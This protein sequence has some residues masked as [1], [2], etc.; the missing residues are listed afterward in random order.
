MSP[1]MPPFPQCVPLEPITLGN[2]KYT[3]SGEVRRV[4]GVT[5][6]SASD[7][8][9]F[10]VAHPKPMPPVATEELKHFKQSVQDTSR[11]AKYV[12]HQISTSC[13]MLWLFGILLV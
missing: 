2:Q 8:H 9:S 4:L 12:V 3:R 11:K 1:D 10:G 6:S 7:D 5:P 13:C